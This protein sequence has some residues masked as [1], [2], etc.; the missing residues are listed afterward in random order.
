MTS[1]PYKSHDTPDIT[2]VGNRL[3][4]ATPPDREKVSNEEE[5]DIMTTLLTS[6]GGIRTEDHLEES[7]RRTLKCKWGGTSHSGNLRMYIVDW[8]CWVKMRGCVA[9]KS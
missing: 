7:A 4:V 5:F 3:I 6:S 2:M 8:D 9:L 1:T